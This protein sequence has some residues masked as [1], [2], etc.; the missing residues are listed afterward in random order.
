MSPRVTENLQKR[1]QFPTEEGQLPRTGFSE[2]EGRV[3]Q[4]AK[5]RLSGIW[6][7]LCPLRVRHRKEKDFQLASVDF[8]FPFRG[9]RARTV[10]PC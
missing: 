3:P 7:G 5:I 1:I 9:T 2:N 6:L 10:V 8:A 4:L